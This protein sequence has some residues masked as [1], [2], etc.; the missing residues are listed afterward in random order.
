M[1]VHL[2]RFRLDLARLVVFASARNALPKGGDLGYGVHLALRIALGDAAPQPFRFFEESGDLLGYSADA[3]ALEAAAALPA[4]A[5][6][7]EAA[8]LVLGVEH[9]AVKPMP[10]TWPEGARYRFEVRL[11]PVKRRG[12]DKRSD[13]RPAEHDAFGTAV[14]GLP[15]EEWPTADDVYLAWIRE[16]LLANGVIDLEADLHLSARKRTEVARRTLGGSAIRHRID[17]PDMVAAGTLRI[18]QPA[19]FS[20]FLARGVGRHKAFGFGMMLLRPAGPR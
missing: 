8:R 10:A 15:K 2:V 16:K 9:M 1:M 5:A 17:G 6:G 13:G 3:A 12:K 18:A 7:I 4:M 20:A 11:R 14:R 19:H